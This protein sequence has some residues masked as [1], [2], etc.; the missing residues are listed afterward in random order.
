MITKNDFE[1][2]L[3]FLSEYKSS[4]LIQID[5]HLGNQLSMYAGGIVSILSG[6]EAIRWNAV[7]LYL[8]RAWVLYL[9]SEFEW[10]DFLRIF[11]YIYN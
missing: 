10:I 6:M 11:L 2:N 8:P 1:I 4:Q 5:D 7:Q 9:R 3:T